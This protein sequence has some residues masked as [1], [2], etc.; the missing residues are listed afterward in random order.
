MPEHE[1]HEEHELNDQSKLLNGSSDKSLL[2]WICR[3][4]TVNAID[5]E[6]K[7]CVCRSGRLYNV[8]REHTFTNDHLA[9]AI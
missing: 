1:E 7:H 3:A 6:L 9:E 8:T 4:Y 2:S 5:F